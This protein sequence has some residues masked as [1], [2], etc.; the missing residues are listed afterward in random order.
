MLTT[1]AAVTVIITCLTLVLYNN[2]KLTYYS[3]LYSL[4]IIIYAPTINI[5]TNAGGGEISASISA[6]NRMHI[7]GLTPRIAG[8]GCCIAARVRFLPI[9]LQ[10]YLRCSQRPNHSSVFY[11]FGAWFGTPWQ[12]TPANGAALPGPWAAPPRSPRTLTSHPAAPDE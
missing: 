11:S 7:R 2:F 9:G 5:I 6:R 4:A 12:A 1:F 8:S 3:E 10:P